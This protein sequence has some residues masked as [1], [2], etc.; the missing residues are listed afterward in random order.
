MSVRQRQNVMEIRKN[1]VCI[2]YATC[3]LLFEQFFYLAPKNIGPINLQNLSLTILSFYGL[4]TLLRYGFPKMRKWGAFQYLSV[5]MVLLVIIAGIMAKIHWGQGFR[6]S[7][8]PELYLM[9][10][11]LSI[12]PLGI[13]IKREKVSSTQLLKMLLFLG[14]TE[15]LV[16]MAQFIAQFMGVY[17][18]T[19]AH[20]KIGY[21][22]TRYMIEGTLIMFVL[23]H[24]ITQ[25]FQYRITPIRAMWISMGLIFFFFMFQ[26][27]MTLLGLIAAVAFFFLTWKTS[28]KR[29]AVCAL[30]LIV[31]AIFVMRSSLF[32]DTINIESSGRNTMGVRVDGIAYYLSQVASSPVFGLGGYPLNE[33]A[34]ASRGRYLGYVLNDNGVFGLMFMYG[35][36]GLLWI[37]TMYASLARKSLVIKKRY[38]DSSFFAFAVYLIAISS[39]QVHWYWLRSALLMLV[40]I[41]AIVQDECDISVEEEMERK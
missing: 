20:N 16:M 13:L 17:F 4:I 1:N 8:M 15:T 33:I 31:A 22:F 2:V 14:K 34:N 35:G 21:S 30:I 5:G 25:S 12:F 18:L 39:S 10:I 6:E 24:E 11:P 41:F 27:R 7:I 40:I 9:V 28:N 38:N 36:L 23:L 26:G 29:K 3:W 37:F 19:A 32:Q